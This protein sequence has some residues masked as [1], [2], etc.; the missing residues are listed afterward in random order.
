MRKKNISNIRHLAMD[1]QYHAQL[2]DSGEN[3]LNILPYILLPLCGSDD[4][5]EE[6]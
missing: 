2:L 1:V 4:F 3:G 5:S 6:V